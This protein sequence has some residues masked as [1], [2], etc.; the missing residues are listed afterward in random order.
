MGANPHVNGGKLRKDLKL[1]DLGKHA[2]DVSEPGQT[3]GSALMQLGEWYADVF[4]LNESER[5]FRIM[6]PDEVAS[7]RLGAVFEATDHA[8][9][10]PLDPEIDTGHAPDG[11]I[12]EVLS[13]HNCQ[14]WL[15]GYVLTGRHGVFPCYE[16][17]I[18]IIDGMVNQYSKF[19][20][21]S[22]EEA[23]WR[24][25]PAGLNYLLTSVG[26]RQD[27]N[28]YSHQMPGFINSMLNRKEDTARVYLPPD[29]NTLLATM[30]KVH[31]S[32]RT[33]NLVIA[34]KHP[35]PQWL[36]I[37]EARE[38]VERGAT[39][40]DFASNDDGDPDIVLAGCGTIPVMELLAAADLLRKHAPDMKVRF[41]GV[42]DLFTLAR[43]EA[44]PHGMDEAAFAEL[45]T[46]DK[47]VLFNFHGYASAVHQLIHRRP[48]Q[49]RFSVRGYAE[50]GTTTTPFELLAMNGVDRFQLAIDALLRVDIEASEAV[51]GM[52]GAFATRTL[53]NTQEVITELTKTR[54]RLRASVVEEG[55][56]PPRSSNG[57]GAQRLHNR[58]RAAERQVGRRARPDGDAVRPRRARR[59]LPADRAG[60][61]RGRA[62]RADPAPLQARHAVRG[63][64]R[65]DRRR[66]TAG[67]RRRPLRRGRS[68][69]SWPRSVQLADNCDVVVCEGTD[70]ATATPALDLD[71]NADLANELG[72]PVLAVVRGD[73]AEAATA[74]ARITR[75]SLEQKG[76]ELF[77]MIV[78]RVPVADMPAVVE[79]LAAERTAHARVRAA[80]AAGALVPLRRRG[81]RGARRTAGCR[82][83]G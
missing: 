76:C 34:S 61:R 22:K 83:Y 27:H 60:R 20:K 49:E 17:F 40:W 46:E 52:S 4:R 68:S 19:L 42:T 7:N 14:G 11:R 36:S 67:D 73:S 78:N 75:E 81:R 62:D 10:W 54:E 65:A 70:F 25:P 50:E 48:A 74:S 35:L 23:P 56:D 55:N 66:G 63:D 33:I 30:E 5:N 15:Q 58:G 39:V 9:E 59:L 29:A 72:C 3:N 12:M 79:Q 77:G 31:K 51:R 18:P 21:M 53:A 57:L 16:A 32:T 13:E 2:L 28:G 80:R 6:C 69:A 24:E 47:P 71:L 82:A 37:D 64:V 38:N 41:V 43:P 26:W 44:H 8:W 1:P 45:Y